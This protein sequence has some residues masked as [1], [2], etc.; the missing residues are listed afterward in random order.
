MTSTTSPIRHIVLMRPNV[1]MVRI[2]AL[3]LITMMEHPKPFRD[4][5]YPSL[6]RGTVDAQLPTTIDS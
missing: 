5:A 6:I 3:W 4:W 1:Q 2:K